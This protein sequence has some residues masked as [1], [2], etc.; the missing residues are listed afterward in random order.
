MS[1]LS[2]MLKSVLTAYLRIRYHIFRFVY[3]Y[4]NDLNPIYL[5]KLAVIVIYIT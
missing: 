3:S 5:L 1:P 2:P 4:F